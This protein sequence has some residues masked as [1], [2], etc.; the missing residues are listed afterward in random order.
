MR[1]AGSPCDAAFV[2]K[3]CLMNGRPR[4]HL[5]LEAAVASYLDGPEVPEET[6]DTLGGPDP[7]GRED[8]LGAP[9]S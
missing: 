1:P 4:T 7:A 9:G 2:A 5:I 8:E 6:R 3:I